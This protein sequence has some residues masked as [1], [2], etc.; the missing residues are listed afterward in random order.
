[1][2]VLPDISLL[3]TFDAGVAHYA[4]LKRTILP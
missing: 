1:M 2:T 3:L 4:H